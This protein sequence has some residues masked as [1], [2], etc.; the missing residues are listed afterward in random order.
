MMI[1]SQSVVTILKIRLEPPPEICVMKSRHYAYIM[2]MQRLK[3][4]LR[5]ALVVLTALTLAAAP[6]LQAYQLGHVSSDCS[7]SCCCD[8]S[9]GQTCVLSREGTTIEG[10]CCCQISNPEPVAEIPF[11]AQP[12]PVAYPDTFAEVTCAVLDNLLTDTVSD[13]TFRIDIP[14]APGPPLY[15]L[16]SSYLI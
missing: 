14:L 5:T 15:I 2:N 9:C 16:N 7:N 8:C 6:C 10:V 11:E 12:R 3:K 4:I 13:Q 1:T